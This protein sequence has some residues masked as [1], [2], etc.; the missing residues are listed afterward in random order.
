MWT[1]TSLPFHP[2]VAILT[3]TQTARPLSSPGL[4]ALTQAG[5]TPR[6]HLSRRDSLCV[7]SGKLPAQTAQ[8]LPARTCL[9]NSFKP[10]SFLI[11]ASAFFSATFRRRCPVSSRQLGSSAA[12]T[13]PEAV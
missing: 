12:G 3:E 2:Y 4:P 13:A 10:S 11:D 5:G 9:K 7:A 1:E 6:P 8:A